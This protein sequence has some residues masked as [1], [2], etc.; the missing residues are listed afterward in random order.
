MRK[1][2]SIAVLLVLVAAVAAGAEALRKAPLFQ[3]DDVNGEAVK[4]STYI[5]DKVVVLDFWAVGCVPCLAVMPHMEDMWQTYRDDGLQVIGISEDLPRNVS[6]VKAK[7]KEI[8]VTYTI[9]LDKNAAALTA[10]QGA[11]A[12][13]PFIV[14]IDYDGNIYQTFRRIQPGDEDKIETAVREA[15]G[16]E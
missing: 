4:L 10:Y 14:V 1:L 13:I 2:F 12:G 16:L 11:D 3:L 7:A 6:S 15:L 8:G 5:G 9:V